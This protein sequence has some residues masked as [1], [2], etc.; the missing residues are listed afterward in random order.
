[1]KNHLCAEAGQSSL[2]FDA[3]VA[4]AS[5]PKCTSISCGG[6]TS[7]DEID[8][9]LSSL[10]FGA[11]VEHTEASN[12]MLGSGFGFVVQS[13][14]LRVPYLAPVCSSAAGLSA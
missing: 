4:P 6:G 12:K 2:R 10:P 9:P 5:V 7:V 8:G 3:E 14:F 13:R 11:S 1:M